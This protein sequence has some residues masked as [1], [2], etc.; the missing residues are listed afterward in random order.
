MGVRVIN[1][2]NN[3]EGDVAQWLERLTASPVLVSSPAV[4]VWG[5]Q[6]QHCFALLNVTRRSH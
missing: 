1:K 3:R 4:P 6:R 2:E 5:F